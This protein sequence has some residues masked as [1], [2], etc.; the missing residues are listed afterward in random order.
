M[1]D[2]TGSSERWWR[3]CESG[4][5][6]EGGRLHFDVE[7][8]FITVFRNKGR[9]SALDSVCHHAAGPLT[10]GALQDIEDLNLTVVLC[11]WHK[12]M[13]SID[14]GSVA[15]PGGLKV[16]TFIG[17]FVIH[18]YHFSS[19]VTLLSRAFQLISQIWDLRYFKE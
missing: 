6:P 1:T 10:L 5:L 4:A 12:F 19:P 11:P 3:L 2:V 13:I 8:R 16:A 14:G 18:F 7:G 17:T 9:L 15:A